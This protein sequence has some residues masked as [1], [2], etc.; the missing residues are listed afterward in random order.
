MLAFGIGA[1]LPLLL[2]GMLSASDDAQ[3]R[4]RLMS[5]GGPMKAV[6]GA[7]LVIVGLLVVDLL[8]AQAEAIIVANQPDLGRP[9][10]RRGSEPPSGASRLCRHRVTGLKRA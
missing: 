7:L 9:I 3:M 5:A 4:A 8:E 1:A 2:L 6:L 10:R